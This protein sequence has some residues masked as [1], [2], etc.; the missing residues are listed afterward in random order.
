MK[1][2]EARGQAPALPPVSAGYLASWW[3]EIGST[4]PTGMGEAPIGWADLAAWQEING[5]ELDP[6]EAKTIR[7]MSS[8]F[9]GMRYEA[10]KPGCPAPYS[11]ETDKDVEDRVTQQFGAIM[12]TLAARPKAVK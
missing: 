6:W 1:A 10:K 9:I 11:V 7:A 4:V 8:A 3:L 12:K 2:L 5:V